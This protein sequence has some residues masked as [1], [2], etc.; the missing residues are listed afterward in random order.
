MGTRCLTI[1]YQEDKEIVVMYRQYDG[2]IEGHGKELADFL[3]GKK[4]VNGINPS[5]DQS[6]IFNGMGCLAASV[7]SEMKEGVGGFYLLPAGTR[8]CWE[9]YIYHIRGDIGL[10][11]HIEV[12][13]GSSDEFIFKGPASKY[14]EWLEAYEPE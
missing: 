2:Y 8:D 9:D 11:P 3:G 1:F 5:D 13:Y 6:L 12:S 10:E 14:N 7:I 4:I